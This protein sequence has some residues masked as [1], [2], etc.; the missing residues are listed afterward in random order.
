MPKVQLLRPLRGHDNSDQAKRDRKHSIRIALLWLAKHFPK[1]FPEDAGSIHPLAIG[2]R[3]QIDHAI[4][5]HREHP[6]TETLL[7]AVS[8]WT[9]S[10]PYLVA[11]AKGRDRINLDGTVSGP[12]KLGHRRY[13]QRLLRARRER[14]KAKLELKPKPPAKQPPRAPARPLL[15]L[16][17]ATTAGEMRS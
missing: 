9:Q 17:K 7:E 3:D 14:L 15:S 1:A 5:T 11:A 10:H 12:I 6:D 8:T 16:R 13:A 2:V 4:R